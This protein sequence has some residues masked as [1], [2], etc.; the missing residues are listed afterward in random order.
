MITSRE[1]AIFWIITFILFCI[2]IRLNDFQ[3]MFD[4]DFAPFL[5]AVTAL[6]GGDF[7][8]RM[9]RHW[10]GLAGKIADTFNEVVDLNQRMAHELP[11]CTATAIARPTLYYT[12]PRYP[13]QP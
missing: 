5:E 3:A 4:A 11:S 12:P 9:P 8:V 6:R 10:T 2:F 13:S 1:R 7:S